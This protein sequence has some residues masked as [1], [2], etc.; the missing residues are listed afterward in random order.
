MERLSLE[1]QAEQYVTLTGKPTEVGLPLLSLIPKTPFERHRPS[2]CGG[3]NL[4][5]AKPHRST[6]ALAL[7]NSLVTAPNLAQLANAATVMML[8]P[9]ALAVH[10]AAL[11]RAGAE[12]SIV[13]TAAPMTVEV[14]AVETSAAVEG[15]NGDCPLRGWDVRSVACGRRKLAQHQAALLK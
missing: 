2:A 5:G 10:W 14:R 4:R 9:A 1:R 3:K 13:F 6:G 7:F 15:S 8:L 12:P 11:V